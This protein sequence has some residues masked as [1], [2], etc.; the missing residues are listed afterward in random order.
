MA[1]SNGKEPNNLGENR[2][3][4]PYKITYGLFQQIEKYNEKLGTKIDVL[5][6]PPENSKEYKDLLKGL[7]IQEMTL[8]ASSYT[9]V[10]GKDGTIKA[11][12]D[13]ATGKELK[14]DDRI[15]DAKIKDK[16]G[17]LSRVPDIAKSNSAETTIGE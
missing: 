7:E 11:R 8:K 17:K 12:I 14:G 16:T 9:K 2:K 6:L 13:N 4:T 3:R 1:D 10:L 15:K 5:N